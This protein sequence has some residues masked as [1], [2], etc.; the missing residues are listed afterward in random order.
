MV[1]AEI[2]TLLQEV[3]G[4]I[5][6]DPEVSLLDIRRAFLLARVQVSS[7]SEAATYG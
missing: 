6:E 4:P 2:V 1:S 3:I 7:P 5:K